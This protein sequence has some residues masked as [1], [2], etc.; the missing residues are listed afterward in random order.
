[1]LQLCSLKLKKCIP[2]QWR[3]YVR[4]ARSERHVEIEAAASGRHVADNLVLTPNCTKSD[5]HF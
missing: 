5:S 2:E 4:S 1:M 3:N